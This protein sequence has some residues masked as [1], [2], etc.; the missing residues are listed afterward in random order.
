MIHRYLNNLFFVTLV[1]PNY[2]KLKAVKILK[3]VT[4]SVTVKKIG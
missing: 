2:V 4:F 3:Y 1:Y